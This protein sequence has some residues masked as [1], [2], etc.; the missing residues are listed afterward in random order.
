[1]KPKGTTPDAVAWSAAKKFRP[2]YAKDLRE[3]SDIACEKALKNWVRRAR[4]NWIAAGCP[5]GGPSFPPLDD[6]AKLLEWRVANMSYA[7]SAKTYQ[8]AA[9]G[10]APSAAEK[11]P[12]ATPPPLVHQRAPVHIADFAPMGFIEAV[13]RQGRYVAAT[14]AAYDAALARPGVTSAELNTLGK[15]RDN[16]LATLRACQGD[17]EKA[18]RESGDRP[19]LNDLRAELAALLGQLALSFVDLL[20]DRIGIPRSRARE[21]AD[22]WFRELAASRFAHTPSSSQAPAPV[23]A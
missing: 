9:A 8:Q 2:S 19:H 14:M 5:S 23:A 15:E 16:A 7:P 18:E 3:Y 22:E 20:V 4:E 13:E 6:P 10:S 1:M 21:L 12:P 17:L 11:E